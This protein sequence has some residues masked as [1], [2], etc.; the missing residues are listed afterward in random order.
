MWRTT[1]GMARLLGSAGTDAPILAAAPATPRPPYVG[2][3]ACA[4]RRTGRLRGGARRTAYR[5]RGT[6]RFVRTDDARATRPA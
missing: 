4:R 3:P 6:R 1:D 2:I 5:A